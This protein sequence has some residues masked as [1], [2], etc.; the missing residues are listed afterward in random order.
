MQFP[1][2]FACCDAASSAVSRTR[3][4]R[5]VINTDYRAC[6]IVFA[7]RRTC[8]R[9]DTVLLLFSASGSALKGLSLQGVRSCAREI[10]D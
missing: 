7:R 10:S 9:R 5:C 1:I 3:G 8:L 2:P 4:R 6:N